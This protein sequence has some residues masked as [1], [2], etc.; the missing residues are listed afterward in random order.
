MRFDSRSCKIGGIGSKPVRKPGA[1]M[2]LG[3]E[4][5][6]RALSLPYEAEG[7]GLRVWGGGVG[8]KSKK[9]EHHCLP[10]KDVGRG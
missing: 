5:G 8:V 9:L 7:S 1:V 3:E 2:C 10:P 6:S 4:Q